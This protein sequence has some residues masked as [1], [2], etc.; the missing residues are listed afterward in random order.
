MD[1]VHLH[2]HTQY[3]LLDGAIRLPELMAKV[4]EYHMPAVAMTDHGNLFGVIEFY[5]MAKDFGI[6]PIIGCEV[7]L[8]PHGYRKKAG[9]ENLYHLVLLAENEKGYH[10]LLKL[11]SISH[12]EGFYYKPRIDKEL[13]NEY[14]EGLIGLSACLRGEVPLFIL[15]D[16]YEEAKRAAKDYEDILGKGNFYLEL[17]DN[18][19]EE[20]I[21]ANE[22]LI[23]ISD[24]LCLPILATN[25]CHYLRS[26]DAEAHDILL[27]IQTGKNINDKNRLHFSTNQFYFK[28]K[29]EMINAFSNYPQATRN[30]MAIAERCQLKLQFG[31]YRFPKFPMPEGEN[32]S[33]FLVKKAKSGLKR[34][35][36]LHGLK[37]TDH[38]FYF[39]RLEKELEVIN[40]MGFASYF[41][42]VSDFATYAKKNGIPVGP[43]RGSAAGSLV[44]Y[45]LDITEIDPISYGLLFERFLNPERRGMPDIDVDLCMEGRDQVL[46]YVSRKYGGRD[47]VAQIITFGKMQARAVIR[48][49]GR[50][51]D[52]PYQQVDKIAK[53]VPAIPNISLKEAIANEP[54]LSALAA[55]NPTVKRLLTV[56][57]VLEGLP[58]HASTHAAGV[59]VSDRPLARYVP[60]YR[61]TKGEV[62]TQFD[63]KGIEQ[64][65]LIKFDL[66]GLKTLTSIQKTL[67]LIE[68]NHNVKIDLS[69]IDLKD[70]ATYKLL[71]Q[72]D[73]CGVFQLESPGMQDLLKRLKP[74][75][76]E[77]LIAIVALYRPGPLESGMIDEFIKRKHG[78]IPIKY[79]L[80]QLESVLKETY[81]VVVY[82]EQVME[83]AVALSGYTL[84]EADMLRKAMG[85][86]KPE[87]MA[88]ERSRFLE[89]ATGKGIEKKKAKRIFDL[90]EKFG[91]YGFNKSH[92]AAYA[93]IAY[94]TAYLKAHYPLEFMA[95]LLTCEMGSTDEVVKYINECQ[96]KGIKVLPPDVNLSE[97]DFMVEKDKIRFGLAAI[98]NV[99]G[100][101]IFSILDARKDGPF[102]S[103]VDFCERVD[104]RRVNRRVIESLIK[105]GAFDSLGAKRKQLMFILPKAIEIGQ[106]RQRQA[107]TAQLSLFAKE[108]EVE[109]SLPEMEEWPEE[110]HLA[111]EKDALGI[112]LTGHP[113]RKY[114][115]QLIKLTDINTEQISHLEDGVPVT[116]GGTV[117]ASKEIDSRRGEKMAFI[118]LEDIKGF[119][120]VIV[121]SEV[122][123]RVSTLIKSDKPLLVKGEI[124]KDETLTKII[125]HEICPLSEVMQGQKKE[126]KAVH[127]K[128][129]PD[130][131]KRAHLLSIKDII[132]A[133]PGD[134]PV[135]LH[136]L[137][138]KE[139]VVSLPS[140][141]YIRP[142]EGF[143]ETINDF[144]GYSAVEIRY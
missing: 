136:L 6:K 129:R 30:T 108:E 21:K 126:I 89:G 49:V 42:I 12:L 23:K 66:L 114:Q 5:G 119:V 4:K 133:H 71:C 132:K 40:Q 80:P 90:I 41:L 79:T 138:E 75:C 111:N 105:A 139:V 27:C 54:R 61:G 120:E 3:S 10:N 52:M 39:E 14:H 110:M 94:R 137:F 50:A 33:D 85:K 69:Q 107:E 35:F 117:R 13:L 70:K 115:Q 83:I 44:A 91:G 86:K 1:F 84:G 9:K 65:G 88:R 101:A 140:Q 72:G 26:E 116:I 95:S 67:E 15:K 144:L 55:K 34:K 2:I 29:E 47:H 56:A 60:L 32:L 73:T 63:M 7:Y 143:V 103:L 106:R 22:G 109:L 98:K 64:V 68:K 123:K 57:R 102:S 87:I 125:A 17:Q 124:S 53:L 24:E 118:T 97:A 112:Y 46:K 37:E 25:D 134:C 62:V 45:A 141:F 59:V 58:R 100:G 127:I 82:Q 93:L 8:A 128:L 36:I 38:A 142:S 11:V 131:L 78:K 99:G 43:G 130:G 74:S 18:G 19:L 121:F 31:E 92:S 16:N 28:S 113:L 135:Y 48:D 20:Q 81:G 77:D 76:F 104:Q 122:Y 51:L 96:E